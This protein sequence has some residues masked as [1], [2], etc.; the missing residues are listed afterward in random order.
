MPQPNER[1]PWLAARSVSGRDYDATYDRR[2]AAG[3]NV[4]GEASFIQSL[5]R[6]SV[7]DAGCGT[8]RVARELARRGLDVVGVDI[9]P[10]ML[11]TA[12][13]KA[14]QL[15]WRLGDIATIDLGRT[16]DCIAMAGNVMIFVTSGTEGAVLTNLAR[17]LVPGGLLVS[18]FQLTGGG[19]SLSTYDGLATDAGLELTERWSTWDR[20]EW[21][22]DS[23]YAVSV[24]R[25]G[26]EGQAPG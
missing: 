14:P 21:R 8:G 20:E 6:S 16:F 19:L 15:D 1:N 24:H 23:T 13:E 17:H 3:E 12:R 26:V 5:G 11:I 22:P 9:D 10:A 2:A 18:G 25:C 4:H 7:L